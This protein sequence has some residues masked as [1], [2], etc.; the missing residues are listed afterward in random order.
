MFET[1]FKKDPLS[2]EAGKA[3]RDKILAVGGSRDEMDSLIDFLG[4]EPS[5]EAILKSLLG[6]DK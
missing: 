3:Y 6:E 2:A 1:N 5:N 4:R